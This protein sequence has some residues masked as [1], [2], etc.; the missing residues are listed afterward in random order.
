M[1]TWVQRYFGSGSRRRTVALA[2]LAALYA[3]AGSAADAGATAL[4][5]RTIGYVL[6]DMTWAVHQT[7]D[8]KSECP[9]GLNALGPREQ[10]EVLFPK[11][12]KRTVLD[13]QLQFEV[14]TWY[15]TASAD[16]F[17]FHEAVGPSDG[18]N[19]D[20]KIGPH[21]FKNPDGTPG[22]DNQLFRAIGCL[23]GFRVDGLQYIFQRL[24]IK[25]E[26]YT[27]TMIELTDVDDLVNDPEVRV[28]IYRGV[29]RLLTDATGDKIV[30]GGSQRI[31]TRWGAEFM[32]QLEGQIVN[33]VLTTRPTAK[34][35]LPWNSDT[36]VPTAQIIH[37]M[38]LQLKIT[39]TAAE[40]V[41]AGYAD[42]EAFYKS[43]IR[44]DAT[45]HLSNGQ[46]SAPSLYKEL[47]RVADAYPDPDTGANTAIS[48]ALNTT[49]TQVFIQHPQ[50]AAAKAELL[51]SLAER[52]TRTALLGSPSEKQPGATQKTH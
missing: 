44:A 46:I 9:D 49:F 30:P 34:M 38:R 45:H 25:K 12:K 17:P 7:A 33:G 29:D 41:I 5:D 52:A 8:G 32:Q 28:T 35:V 4:R 27:R 36:R 16:R 14:N 15:P 37:D 24:T 19:L 39:P 13:T 23:V 3:S 1:K 31:D 47:R 20:G 6:T 51:R 10:F 42:V 11:N 43:L 48:A 50:G 40:G 18:L 22:I 2:A 21:D 26:R